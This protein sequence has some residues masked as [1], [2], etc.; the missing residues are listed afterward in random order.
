[1]WVSGALGDIRQRRWLE[2]AGIRQIT[3][4]GF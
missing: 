3:S 2:R 1:M 4:S